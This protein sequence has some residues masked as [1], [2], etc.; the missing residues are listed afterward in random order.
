MFFAYLV[1]RPALAAAAPQHRPATWHAVLRRFL[2][3]VAAAIAALFVTGYV[4]IFAGRGGFAEV[5]LHVHLMHGLAVVMLTIF[6][7]LVHGPRGRFRRGRA[8]GAASAAARALGGIRRLVTI[9][10]AFGLVTAVLAAAGR[11]WGAS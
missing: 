6:A 5:G 8:A 3:R 11:W 1:L 4:M 9:N 2:R 10:P 7:A